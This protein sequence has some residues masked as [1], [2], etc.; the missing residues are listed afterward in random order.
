MRFYLSRAYILH[1][2]ASKLMTW[3]I[4]VKLNIMVIMVI[5]D[6]LKITSSLLLEQTNA[7][8]HFPYLLS[9]FQP[10]RLQI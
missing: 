6:T 10:L 8:Q 5:K 3:N 9:L 7:H 1:M 2:I 4:V